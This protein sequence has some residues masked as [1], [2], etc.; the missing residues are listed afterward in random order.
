M[1]MMKAQQ[2]KASEQVTST[3]QSKEVKMKSHTGM[4]GKNYARAKISSAESENSNDIG[5][6]HDSQTTPFTEAFP[7]SRHV[8]PGK[9]IFSSQIH[10][11]AGQPTTESKP[12]A[13]NEI[14]GKSLNFQPN[15][16]IVN[17]NTISTNQN[18]TLV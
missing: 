5:R 9:A 16:P 6:M 10:T 13:R 12:L 7:I 14:K 1:Q 15:M 11:S 18:R 4:T 3:K 17:E 2:T 8:T